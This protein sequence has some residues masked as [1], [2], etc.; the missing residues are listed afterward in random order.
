MIFVLIASAVIPA[1]FPSFRILYILSEYWVVEWLER[2]AGGGS[3][4]FVL[5]HSE[6]Y[7]NIQP[8]SSF[9]L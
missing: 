9:N 4:I 1:A 3:V 8:I 6:V 2:G 5:I 7:Q